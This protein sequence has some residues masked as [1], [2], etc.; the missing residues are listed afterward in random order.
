MIQICS[1]CERDFHV[2]EFCVCVSIGLHSSLFLQSRSSLSSFLYKKDRWIAFYMHVYSISM[3]GIF[4][5]LATFML[6]YVTCLY[7]F[8]F[9]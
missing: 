7:N 4:S 1:I 9:I 6:F 2:K 3:R 8:I 5:I